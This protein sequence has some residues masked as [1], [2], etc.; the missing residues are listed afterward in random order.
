MPG[1]EYINKQEKKALMKLFDEGGV[2]F[3]HGFDAMR[4]KYHVRE[5]EQQMNNFFNSN[6]TLCVS[7]GTAAI[8]CALVGLGVKRGDEVITQS[9]NFI[10]TVEA[11]YDLGAKPIIIGIDNTLNMCP[12]QLSESI[13]PKTKA[14]IP[15]HMLG[16]PAKMKEIIAIGKKNK[17]PIIEDACEA[18]GAKYDGRFVGT[19]CQYGIFSFD[20]GKTK[21]AAFL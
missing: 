4:K 7:S 14:I 16:V 5:F 19:L 17:I 18:V 12:K 1:Y 2:L 13:G 10:A 21:P 15:V 20:F 9:F 8:K 6:S 11:I 3:A